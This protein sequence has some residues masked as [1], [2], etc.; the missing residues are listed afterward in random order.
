MMIMRNGND[1]TTEPAAGRLGLR[2]IRRAA[3]EHLLLAVGVPVALL[4]SVLF[5][6]WW[7]EPVYESFT[8]IRIDQER[9]GI[10]I[11]EALRT[12][13]SGSKIT[14]EMEELRSRTLA[15]GV[16][17][18][19]ALGAAVVQPRKTT[20]SALFTDIRA[21][22]S[23]EGARFTLQRVDN[24]R[25]R[26]SGPGVQGQEIAAGERVQLPGVSF[27]LA[28]AATQHEEIV[29]DVAPFSEAVEQFQASLDVSRPNREAD[30]IA[31]T[32]QSTDPQLARAVPNLIAAQF[33]ARRN[34]VRTSD[35]RA[36]A[37]FL[38]DQIGTLHEQLTTTE[39]QLRAFQEG[40]GVL[41]IPAQSEAQ[42]TRLATMQA[43]RE[44]L[45]VER[46]SVATVLNNLAAQPSDPLAPSPYRALLGLPSILRNPASAE[47]LASLNAAEAK[48]AEL[49]DRY[50]LEA[51]EVQLVTQHIR[52]LESSLGA[53][54]MTYLR[55]LT[56]Q[57]R[58]LDANL[59]GV[60]SELRQIPEQQLQ[61][62]RLRRQATATEELYTTLTGRLKEAQILAAL[63]DPTVRVMDPAIRP[64]RPVSPN[65][66]LSIMLALFAGLLLGI[67][68]AVMREQMDDTVRSRDQLQLVGR[69]PVLG[70][71]PRLALQTPEGRRFAAFRPV[72][73][74][75]N[76]KRQP[77]LL[78]MSDMVPG[79]AEAYR[80][81]RTNITFARLNHAP[82]IMVLTSP[83]PGDGKSTTA[84]N[85]AITMSQQGHRCLLVDADLRR[86]RLHEH[87]GTVRDPGLSNVLLGQVMIDDV[88]HIDPKGGPSVL[89]TGTLPPN[90]AELLGSERMGALL[91]ELAQTYDMIIIDAPPLNLVTDAAVLSRHADGVLVVARA[92]VTQQG[93][94]TYTF[95]QLAAVNALVLGTILNDADPQRERHYG[96][97]MR[98]YYQPR[99]A[100]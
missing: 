94:L 8:T 27:V 9:S 26:V 36:T 47:V 57:V 90:P 92:G 16:V 2:D 54:A 46:Q 12:L 3:R 68:G 44:H 69:V 89:P 32:Y 55:G 66:P 43:E 37:V 84:A 30:L 56:E 33:I 76:G 15:E 4:A 49:L 23:E 70:S 78:V 82:R 20:R 22:R 17:D 87:F 40:N 64:L 95:A 48:R 80:S 100:E 35:A 51:P 21:A 85:L 52:Q 62:A 96:S 91:V 42:V 10:A 18:S 19:L 28:P 14:T 65:A 7:T 98:D 79:V 75:T 50:K 29:L 34:D 38:E 5:F 13:S 81:L 60:Q 41:G 67:G 83:G 24:E 11:V 93:A 63:D 59:A 61:L 45:D 86:G 73:T 99:A 25:Y 6:L 77:S 53:L 88:V 97:Y 58:G 31:V 74:V 1:Q 71:I 39:N 72:R